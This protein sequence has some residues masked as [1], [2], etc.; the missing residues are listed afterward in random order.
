MIKDAVSASGQL[1]IVVR[2]EF[3]NVKR[4]ETLDNLVVTVGKQFMAARMTSNPPSVMSHIAI[5][6]SA[7]AA[8]AGNTTLGAETGRGPMVDAG[9]VA[10]G[11]IVT[12]EA[13]LGPG[14]GTGAIVEAGLFNA[15]AG[16]TMKCR[17]VFPVVNKGANDSMT[18]TWNVTFN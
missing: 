18:I 16:G 10:S 7:A 6:T 14:V 2:D 3:G 9:G 4:D 5:G 11:Q 8:A 15:P 12:Y 1:R 13:L 17:T